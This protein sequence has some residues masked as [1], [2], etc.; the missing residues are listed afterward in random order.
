MYNRSLRLQVLLAMCVTWAIFDQFGGRK[1]KHIGVYSNKEDYNQ[2][3]NHY[4]CFDEVKFN[5]TSWKYMELDFWRAAN[6][7]DRVDDMYL[8]FSLHGFGQFLWILFDV[9]EVAM[10]QNRAEFMSNN[11]ISNAG[12][13]LPVM[14]HGIQDFLTLLLIIMVLIGSREILL[15]VI[16]ILTSME[17]SRECIQM[18][19]SIKKYFLQ[20]SNF[21]DL[22]MVVMIYLLFMLPN[23]M[24]P[25]SCSISIV[26]FTKELCECELAK[27]EKTCSIKRG[28]AAF[29]IVVMW[30]RIFAKIALHPKLDKLNLYMSMFR[31]VQNTFLKFVFFYSVYII[32]FGLGFYILLHQDT[33]IDWPGQQTNGTCNSE[34]QEKLKEDTFRSPWFSFLKTVIMLLGELDYEI[35]LSRLNGGVISKTL[36]CCFFLFFVFMLNMVLLNLLNAMAISDTEKIIRQSKVYCEV[37]T[38]KTIGYIEL[39]VFNSLRTLQNISTIFSCRLSMNKVLTSSGVMLFQSRYLDETRSLLRL[40]LPGEGKQ[41]R[42]GFIFGLIGIDD[43]CEEILVEAREILNKMKRKREKKKKKILKKEKDLAPSKKNLSSSS[44]DESSNSSSDT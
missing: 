35:V 16:M 12:R 33:E 44:T 32:S 5:W 39:V 15:L 21:Y 20:V 13:V 41:G 23:S 40:P 18:L 14:Y 31:Q 7:G 24:F 6:D 26:N 9:V 2:S 10:V 29:T 27:A 22:S 4:Q 28:I 36:S 17:L 8:V 37:S 34:K 42:K 11:D 30:V 3:F 25:D 1:W 43:E 38:I 19:A